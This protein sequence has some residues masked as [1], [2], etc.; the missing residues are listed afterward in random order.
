MDAI[1]LAAGS[2]RRLGG[3]KVGLL[4]GG[5]P[6]VSHHLRVAATAGCARVVVVARPE[7]VGWLRA[8]GVDAAPSQAPDPAGS[9]AEGARALGP[10]DADAPVLVTP[11]DVI[12]ALPSTIRALRDAL[13][14]GL[15][16]VTPTCGGSG[17]HPVILRARALAPYLDGAAPP[18][19][20]VLAALGARRLRLA[21]DDPAVTTDL[22]T[23]EDVARVTGGPPRF[24]TP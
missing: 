8:R 9:L 7:D 12:P 10:L 17:G 13:R 22:D 16:A 19:R 18:L 4:L 15:D 11:V 2:G 23:V 21:V 5:V 24:W 14:P 3:A 1:V 6:I 20:D